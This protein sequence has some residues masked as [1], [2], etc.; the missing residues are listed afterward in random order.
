MRLFPKE[1][2]LKKIRGFYHDDG[3][4]EV[5]TGVRRCGMS[6][7]VQYIAEDLRVG[8]INDNHITY[9]D[10]DRYGYRSEKTPKQHEALIE[11][12]LGIPGTKYLFIDEM[13]KNVEGFEDVLNEFLTEGGSSS[14]SP[15]TI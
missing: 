1:N 3:M 11:P 5:I 2:Y 15:P 10:L 6:C 4:I 12:L 14:A 13:Q 9:F 7:L 8:D